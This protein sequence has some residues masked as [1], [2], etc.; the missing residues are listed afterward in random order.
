MHAITSVAMDVSTGLVP[1]ADVS[2][3]SIESRLFTTKISRSPIGHVDEPQS[4]YDPVDLIVRTSGE[5]RL[6]DFLL[7]QVL[8]SPN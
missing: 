6:S 4:T 1:E 7:W 8:I 5:I 3:N 2:L